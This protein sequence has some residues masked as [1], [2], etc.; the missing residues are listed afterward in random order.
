MCT[1]LALMEW[2]S[3][4]LAIASL[5]TLPLAFLIHF[6]VIVF[7][8]YYSSRISVQ[9]LLLL[10]SLF[11]VFSHFISSPSLCYTVFSSHHRQLTGSVN[12]IERRHDGT[13]T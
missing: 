11:S 8:G 6:H 4:T 2:F 5:F 3:L 7:T 1:Q 13:K 10:F 9:F 12:R